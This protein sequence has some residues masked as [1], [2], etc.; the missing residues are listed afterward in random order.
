ME[1]SGQLHV[2]VNLTRGKGPRDPSDMRLV[3]GSRSVR[4]RKGKFSSYASY[5]TPA[6]AYVY[7]K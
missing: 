1:V 3:G 6:Y 2:S 4:C 7:L 5:L